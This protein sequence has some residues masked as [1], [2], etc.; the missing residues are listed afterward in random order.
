[1]FLQLSKLVFA[2]GVLAKGSLSSTS[3]KFAISNNEISFD[4]TGWLSDLLAALVTNFVPKSIDLPG[5]H[6]NS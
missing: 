5:C 6:P 1:M 4:V 2:L 3:V